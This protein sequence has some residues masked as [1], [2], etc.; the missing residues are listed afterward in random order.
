[1]I[2]LQYYNGSEWV[3]VGLFHNDWSAW[4]SLGGDDMNYRTIDSK[5]KV[6]T[7]KSV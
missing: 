5:N 6:L 4:A 7:D 2:T 3:D 1:M